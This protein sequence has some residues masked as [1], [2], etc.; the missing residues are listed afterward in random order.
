MSVKQIIEG[1]TNTFL[2][3]DW[4]EKVSEKRLEICAKCPKQSD[5]AKIE[6]YKTIRRD[7]HCTKC[8]CPLIS[9]TRCTTCKC[10]LDKWFPEDES[11]KS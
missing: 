2:K 3:E 1:W 9:K 10:P 11:K 6:G 8:G 7:L 4:I 5:N